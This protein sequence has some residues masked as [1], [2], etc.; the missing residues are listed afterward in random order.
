MAAIIKQNGGSVWRL[1]HIDGRPV[2]RGEIVISRGATCDRYRVQDGTP[3]HKVSSSGRVDV[4]LVNGD[5]DRE[6]FPHVFNLHWVEDTNDTPK[7]LDCPPA[8]KRVVIIH[9]IQ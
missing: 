9:F 5:K 8:I 3:P 7:R 2:E 1:L 4:R 6:F